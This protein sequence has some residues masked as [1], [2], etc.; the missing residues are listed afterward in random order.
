MNKHVKKYL[1]SE[2]SINEL[3][4]YLLIA[5]PIIGFFVFTCYPMLWA[6]SKS[7]FYY[8]D[9]P[10]ET[11]FVGLENYITLFKDTRY[12]ESWITTFKFALL[13]LPIEIP[14]ALITATILSKK[15]K[16]ATIFR[17]IY[18]V[19]SVLSVVIVG[20]LFT[21]LF[22]YFGVING[23]LMNLGIIETEIDWFA[24][25]STSLVVLALGSCWITFGINVVYFSGALSNVSEDLYEAAD[26]DGANAIIKFFKITLPS[27]MPVFVVL[28]LLAINGTLQ[29]G[30]YI[31]TMTGGEPAG[32]THTV[33]SYMIKSF[34]PGFA[35]GSPNLGYGSAMSIVSSAIFCIIAI[36]YTKL[37]NK[38]TKD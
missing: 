10:S 1:S 33:G 12:W 23:A 13:K 7:L 27:I 19:P 9:V 2:K 34:L 37:S 24:N 32:T 26:I 29:Q 14:G 16:G 22:D 3:Q 15:I 18:F 25:T 17:T 6:A 38:L 31:I 28:L 5:L 30:E 35:S 8:N 20:V 11:K 36:I 4:C 21:S